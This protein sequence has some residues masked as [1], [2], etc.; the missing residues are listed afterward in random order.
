MSS[1]RSGQCKAKHAGIAKQST[2]D[3][4]AEA[5]VSVCSVWFDLGLFFI[6]SAVGP[7][8]CLGVIQRRLM[9]LISTWF[10]LQ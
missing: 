1:E 9:A 10:H 7:G 5:K 8:Q 3:L 2:F 4:D 6:C